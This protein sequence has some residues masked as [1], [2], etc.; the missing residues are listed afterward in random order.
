[1]GAADQT[2][3]SPTPASPTTA[4][5][6]T[7]AAATTPMS[8]PETSSR[9]S[10]HGPG[11]TLSMAELLQQQNEYTDLRY[12]V[13]LGLA[14]ACPLM[15]LLP[16][17]KLD[18]YTFGLGA[19]LVFSLNEI[20]KHR[21]TDLLHVLAGGS[22]QARQTD[23]VARGEKLASAW[24]GE[25]VYGQHRRREDDGMGIKDMI[26]ESVWDVWQQRDKRTRTPE[27]EEEEEEMPLGER[28]K[29]H[30]LE[31]ERKKALETIDDIAKPSKK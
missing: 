8:T 5:P 9:A 19:T 15:M 28:V 17:R 13:A 11:A 14:V 1:M 29:K 6:P 3:S 18:L 25:S 16:P 23:D 24:K 4:S 12:K 31:R 21:G 7:A 10:P 22:K 2:S 26:L 30:T 20:A 27:E